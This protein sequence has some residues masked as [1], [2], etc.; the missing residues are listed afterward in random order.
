MKASFLLLSCL[1]FTCNIFSQTL[2]NP[3]AIDIVR[4]SFGVPHIFA[5]TDP[6][7][8]YGLAWAEAEDEFASM[9]QLLLPVKGLM[10][11]VLGKQ[12]A[13]G[14]YA[15]ALFR[16]KEITEEKWNTLS[17]A[18]IKYIT[19][20][21][22]ALNLYAATH[23][24]E[25]LNKNLFPIT[26]KEFVSSSVFALTIF[27]GADG[28]LQRIFSNAEP[29][30]P[31]LNKKGSN[32]AAV[33]NTKT[34]TGESFL[35]INAHQP[36][37]GPQA[38]YEAHICSEEGLNVLGGLLAGAPCILH[39]VNENLGWAHTVNYCDRLDEFQLQMNPDNAMQY[40]FDGQWTN[41]EV[42]TIKLAIKGIPIKIKRKVYWSK[43][44]ATMKNKTGFY[45]IRLGANMKIG[46]LDQW[47]QMDKAK[48]Y[49]EFYAALN[50]Q[51]LSMFNIMYADKHDTIFYINNAL[52]P[53]RNSGYNWLKTVPGNT[54]N[55]LWTNF[56]SIKE[57]PQYINPSS[58]FLFNTNHSSFLA[59]A[60]ADNLKASS[61]AKQ[62]GWETYN[63][64][65]SV[66]F[67]ELFPQNEKLSYEQFKA[68]KFDKQ[69]PAVLQYNFNID[70]M[71]L[72]N[73]IEYPQYTSIISAL[74]NWDKK[75]NA[76]SKGAAIFLLSY[77]YLK[78]KLKG[79]S[80]RK[81]TRAEAIETF[82]Y[83]KNYLQTNFAK[84]DIALGDLQKLVRGKREWPLGGFPDVLSPQWTA[85]MK[86][87][88][89]K[90]IGGDGLIMFVR[91]AKDGLPKIETINMYGASSH[92]ESKHFDDQVEMYL[93][94]KTKRMTLD[95]QEIY[96]NAE[97]VYHPQ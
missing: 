69:L 93:Q 16:C 65:R 87:G 33:L 20:Y 60:T 31:E 92:P 57:L 96:K 9:Q 68:I 2:I 41:L 71:F 64:N 23:K 73:E 1:L 70:S 25:V 66:R 5:K 29:D 27:N 94:Q 62:D 84:T 54:S 26:L 78:K 43:Y 97:K 49:T 58:G 90:S 46:V 79:Q 22:Q 72:L 12:G 11:K 80:P 24:S 91:F 36:N 59:T 14:D 34:T 13:A 74:K 89:L 40:M 52:M 77:E 95:K 4:D 6:E 17:P 86:D 42:K 39:G 50:K 38:F 48:N 7:V 45:S 44:G 47:Y 75:G 88:R 85:P 32:S 21:V 37:T 55:T 30:A 51:E 3:A 10:G 8:A 18:F 76:E 61:F 82:D 35:L 53:V 15:F 67:M 28:A 56:R 81:I 63:L 83:V 19:G